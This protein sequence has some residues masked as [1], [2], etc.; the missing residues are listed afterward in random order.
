MTLR[1]DRPAAS[2]LAMLL[3]TSGCA[4]QPVSPNA[5]AAPQV[6][7]ARASHGRP[8]DTTSILKLLTKDVFIG[9]TIDPDNGDQGPRAISI[10]PGK[11]VLHQGDLVVCNFENS[12]GTAGDG[13]TLEILTAEPSSSP[14]RFAQNNSIEGCDANVLNN[15]N[16][17]FAGGL[18][19]GELVTFAND[20]KPNRTYQ[21]A[22]IAAPFSDAYAPAKQNFAPEYVYVGTTAGGIV[23]ISTG[24]YGDGIAT[25]VVEGFAVNQGSALG[26][27][28]PS[29]LQYD[30]SVDTLY[31]V[32]GVTNTIVAISHASDLLEENEIIVKTG[33]TK[34][35]C[36][37]AKVTCASLVYQGSPLDAPMASALLPNGNLIVANTQ[38]TANMLVELT[39]QGQILDTKVIDSS[40]TQGVYGLVAAGTDD[41]NTVLFFTDTN[42]NTVQELE[43]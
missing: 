12:A 22:P 19:S 41:S 16:S 6:L 32:D 7:R 3:I 2:S 31:V 23:S 43:Q 10:V 13:T 30:L 8:A 1:F 20:G 5:A 26:M 25:Q 28:A 14:T 42:S 11:K 34:F 27:L 21:G 38:G 18:T 36:K 29:G 35:K 39:P 33:G 15:D 24:P 37:H 17:V 4:G 9:S 40:A